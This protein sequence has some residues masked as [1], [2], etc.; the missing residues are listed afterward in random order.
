LQEV[1]PDSAQYIDLILGGLQDWWLG[2]ADGR[3]DKPYIDAA[4]WDIE[5][6]KRGLLVLREW[7]KM[8]SHPTSCPI[9]LLDQCRRLMTFEQSLYIA[10]RSQLRSLKI[11]LNSCWLLKGT[12]SIDTPSMTNFL[13]IKISSPVLDLEK[14]ILGAIPPEDFRHFMGL[15]P[16]LGSV[17]ILWVTR[18]AQ[19]GCEIPHHG[20]IVGLARTICSEL[21]APFTTLEIDDVGD[22][23][24]N[25]IVKVFRRF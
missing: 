14:P 9:L 24:C 3:V 11:L 15:L 12:Q 18:S 6:R 10:A 17:G 19:V 21:S 5:L 25:A 4:W 8:M 22:V 2:E 7:C 13:H 16:K 1:N 23:G 20:L